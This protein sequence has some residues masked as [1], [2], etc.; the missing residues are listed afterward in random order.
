MGADGAIVQTKILVS[1]NYLRVALWAL[2]GTIL[3]AAGSIIA[4]IPQVTCSGPEGICSTSNSG[5]YPGLA[6][7]VLGLILLCVAGFRFEQV[8]RSEHALSAP[9][10][11]LGPVP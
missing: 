10:T 8:S 2:A 9:A 3:I 4:Y 6:L 7:G 5:M 1:L 11:A